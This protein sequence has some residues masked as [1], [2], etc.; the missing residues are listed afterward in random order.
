ML[1][2][3]QID[4]IPFKEPGNH[5]LYITHTTPEML[6]VLK[7]NNPTLYKQMRAHEPVLE[8]YPE[9]DFYWFMCDYS[10]A[11]FHGIGKLPVDCTLF[12]DEE[13]ASII[14]SV[15]TSITSTEQVLEDF[16]LKNNYDKPAPGSLLEDHI[17]A[18][19]QMRE[20]LS[21]LE[22]TA[23]TRKKQDETPVSQPQSQ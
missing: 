15:K 23:N 19:Q 17:I 8:Y 12:S 11:V 21:A 7:I 14:E 6:K 13:L 5:D 4:A 16:P 2:E 20:Y 3:E 10:R 18:L 1:T 22:Q 9:E